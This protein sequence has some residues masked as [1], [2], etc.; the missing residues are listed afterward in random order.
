[1]F[2]LRQPRQP[3]FARPKRFRSSID[4]SANRRLTTVQIVDCGRFN[5]STDSA[6]ATGHG[7]A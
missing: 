5:L 7:P 1:M 6:H 2:W 3:K 4:D